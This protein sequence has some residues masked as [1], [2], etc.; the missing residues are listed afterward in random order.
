MI[1]DY[2][3]L[4]NSFNKNDEYIN[5]ISDMEFVLIQVFPI[6]RLLWDW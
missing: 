3:N 2:F 1:T 4:A 6:F 5:G